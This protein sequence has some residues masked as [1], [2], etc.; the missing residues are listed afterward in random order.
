GTATTGAGPHAGGPGA[1]RI[2]VPLADMART[3]SG[4][5]LVLGAL[6]LLLLLLLD[7]SK[8]P[9]PVQDR[10]RLLLAAM[11]AQGVLGYTQ[12]FT[13][14]PALLVGIHVFGATVVWCAALWFV[15]GLWHHAPE[16]PG[17]PVRAFG[18]PDVEDEVD[19]P[20]AVPAR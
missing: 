10:A 11:A 8:A 2:P 18:T 17:T 13:H 4:V 15:D 19:R 14:L 5:V 6:M 12:Y 3:H 16:H 20:A 1:K 9:A 7:R